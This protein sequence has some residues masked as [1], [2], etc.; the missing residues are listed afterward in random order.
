MPVFPLVGSQMIESGLSRPS[1]SAPS[2]MARATRSLMLPPGLRNSALPK[3]FSPFSRTN[4]VFP[5][6]SRMLSVSMV[7]G[8]QSQQSHPVV[9]A[10]GGK[11]R[12]AG[13]N[14]QPPACKAG[15]LPVEL[16]PRETKSRKAASAA[17]G[18]PVQRERLAAICHHQSIQGPP[19]RATETPGCRRR[20][21]RSPIGR[22]A[23]T[24][25]PG[26]TCYSRQHSACGQLKGPRE[27]GVTDSG[28][29]RRRLDQLSFCSRSQTTVGWVERSEPHQRE[30]NA[31]GLVGLA[32]LDPPYRCFRNRDNL[33]R[34]GTQG[35]ESRQ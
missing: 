7:M 24:F 16:R 20:P 6:R 26:Y 27:N 21:R 5:I 25:A 13:S 32:S 28:R 29:C 19:R 4:G 22:L 17:R 18:A 11:W 14:R 34:R 31:P 3:I 30:R 10:E 15:A 2:S 33:F 23:L 9:V 12:R 1:R 35:R 8:R